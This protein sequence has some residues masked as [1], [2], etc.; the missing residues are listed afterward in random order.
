MLQL[1]RVRY[2]YGSSAVCLSVCPSVRQALVTIEPIGPNL[3]LVILWMCK[4]EFVVLDEQWAHV[5]LGG[6]HHAL[7]EAQLAHVLRRLG[8][9]ADASNLAQAPLGDMQR[10]QRLRWTLAQPLRTAVDRVARGRHLWLDERVAD[11]H[12]ACQLVQPIHQRHL[13][14]QRLT[15]SS[16]SVIS[17]NGKNGNGKRATE[18][19]ATEKKATEKWATGKKGI[20]STWVCPSNGISIGS[21]VFAQYIRVS[22]TQTDTQ[23]TLRAS[24]VGI[25]RIYALHACDAAKNTGKNTGTF[26]ILHRT[27]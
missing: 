20:A 7:H 12:L 3:H 10:R 13:L 5:L 2:W 17:A 25:G 18:I 22:D 15:T 24:S 8:D 4:I 16:A 9:E 11:G 6:R 1:C 14:V 27:S 19:W 23:T 26:F 21:A